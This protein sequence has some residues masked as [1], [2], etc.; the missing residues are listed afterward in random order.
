M[1]RGLSRPSRTDVHDII[2]LHEDSWRN[3]VPLSGILRQRLYLDNSSEILGSAISSKGSDKMKNKS[4]IV[5]GGAGFI[6]SNIVWS[7]FRNNDVTVL[8][9][10]STGNIHNIVD[11]VRTKQISFVKGSVADLRLMKRICKNTDY[12]LH[13]AAI[14][15]VGR[16]VK[17]PLPTNEANITGTLTTLVASRDAGVR[18]VIIASSSSVYG[19]TPTLPKME[20]MQVSPVSPYG[21]TKVTCEGYCRLFSEIYGLKT[22]ALRYFNVYG[23]RQNPR[24]D[25]AAVIP[26]FVSNAVSGKPLVIYGDGSQTRDFTFVGD[27]VNANLLAASSGAQGVFNIGS[28]NRVSVNSL[29]SNVLELTHSRSRVVHHKPRPGDIMH[30]LAD[31]RKA[32]RI[33]GYSPSWNLREGLAETIERMSRTDNPRE[34]E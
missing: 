26:R 10:L 16:S 6:G 22:V 1:A 20:S 18:K 34:D 21:L 14:P 17:N 25:Y 11:L 32:R 9:N 28:G 27:A 8:D 13:Q 15:S 4:V 3:Y 29:A 23:P 33:L 2:Q 24:T 30:S 5:T 19:E 7:I 12:V 31:I